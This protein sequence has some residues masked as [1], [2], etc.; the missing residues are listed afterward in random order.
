MKSAEKMKLGKNKKTTEPAKLKTGAKLKADR[1]S[2]TK[3]KQKESTGKVVKS[4]MDVKC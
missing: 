3:A 2:T 4:K 1:T